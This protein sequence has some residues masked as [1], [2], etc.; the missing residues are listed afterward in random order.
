MPKKFLYKSKPLITILTALIIFAAAFFASCGDDT[1]TPPQSEFDPPRF[2][3]RSI[4]I[5]SYGFSCMWANDTSKIF[6]SNPY[7][8]SLYILSGGNITQHNIG[9][10]VINDMEGISENELYLFGTNTTNAILT[11]IKWNGTGFEYYPTSVTITNDY[12]YSVSGCIAASGNIWICSRNGIGHLNQSAISNYS[13]EDVTAYINPIFLT[14][15]E[16]VQYST[17]KELPSGDAIENLFEFRDTGFVKIFTYMQNSYGNNYIA[18][19]QIAGN[20][21]GLQ[22][23][24]NAPYL[25]IQNFIDSN[26][27]PYF[28]FN[29]IIE[30][31]SNGRPNFYGN[32]MQDFMILVEAE[33]SL[34]TYRKGL[35]HWNGQKPSVEIADI[36]TNEETEPY[37]NL[38]LTSVNE[39]IYMLL[40][41]STINSP[42][43]SLNVGVKK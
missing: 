25:C 7:E 8:N 15:L 33:G 36:R 18:L 22:Y 31:I 37:K 17:F 41:P 14:N 23:N 38:I 2:N 39:N 27:S 20:K 24:R 10:Y 21:F 13:N 40:Q 19:K 9:N 35:L 42:N 34:F 32:S 4:E 12:F 5:P 29:S 11:I 6:L 30:G 16:E 28:C 43:F 3:W 1:V 26:F